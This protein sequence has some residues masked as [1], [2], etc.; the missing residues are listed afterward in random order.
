VGRLRKV[1]REELRKVQTKLTCKYCNPNPN[2]LKKKWKAFYI[3]DNGKLK[4]AVYSWHGI[5]PPGEEQTEME[6]RLRSYL[7]ERNLGYTYLYPSFN[8]H[9]LIIGEG[10]KNRRSS[11]P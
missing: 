2:F 9:F 8:G 7:E 6:R 5:Y 3:I 4:A 10:I 1:K 11:G